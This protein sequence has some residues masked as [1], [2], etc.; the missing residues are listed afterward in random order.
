MVRRGRLASPTRFNPRTRVGCDF[1]RGASPRAAGRFQSTHP[2]GVRL[3]HRAAREHYVEFQSTHPRGVRLGAGRRFCDEAVSIHAPAWGATP[4]H[5]PAGRQKAVSIHA[6]AWGAT[7]R[8]MEDIMAIRVSIHAPAWGATTP[9]A[10][11]LGT[12]GSFNPR[13]RVGCDAHRHGHAA[14]DECVSIHAPAWGAT[15]CGRLRGFRGPCFNPRTRVGCDLI[16]AAP[17][18]AL[19]VVSIHAPAWGATAMACL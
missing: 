18:H 4:L 15:R 12:M 8:V 19:G 1:R 11:S 6:P 13:T 3:Y 9:P 5:V 16:Q 2:R 10:V 7:W 17:H 14:I